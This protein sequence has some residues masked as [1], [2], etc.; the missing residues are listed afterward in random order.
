MVKSLSKTFESLL[1]SNPNPIRLGDF[2]TTDSKKPK[3][4]GVAEIVGSSESS[5]DTFELVGQELSFQSL[6]DGC[7]RKV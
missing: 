1:N 7:N 3:R 5:E 4:A 6:L 2:A